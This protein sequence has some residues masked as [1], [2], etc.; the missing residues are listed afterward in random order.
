MDVA[1]YYVTARKMHLCPRCIVLFLEYDNKLDAV[2]HLLSQ[3]QIIVIEHIE[4]II[5][6]HNQTWIENDSEI[7][8][9]TS[10]CCPCCFNSLKGDDVFSDLIDSIVDKLLAIEGLATYPLFID[11]NIPYIIATISRSMMQT[12]ISSSSSTYTDRKLLLSKYEEVVRRMIV[13]KLKSKCPVYVNLVTTA[14]DSKAKIVISYHVNDQLSYLN[15][16]APD[17]YTSMNKKRKYRCNGDTFTIDFSE[18]QHF[19]VTYI[20]H[21]NNISEFN[22]AKDR[23]IAYASSPSP[24]SVNSTNSICVIGWSCVKIQ[25]C[26]I[27]LLGRYR[28]LARDVPQS[29]WSV[30]V[31]SQRKGRNS[32]D[33][34]IAH[35]VNTV[36]S[37][38]A[39]KMHAC[40][41]EDID[42]RCLG[43]GR[44][45]VLEVSDPHIQPSRDLL[46]LA[47]NLV[48]TRQGLNVCGDVELL[49]LHVTDKSSW[50]TMQAVAEEKRKAYTCIV[51]SKAVLTAKILQSIEDLTNNATTIDSDGRTCL[52]LHQKTPLRVLHRRSLLDRAKYIYNIK[53]IKLNAHYFVMSMVTSAG[54]YVKEFIHGDLNRTIPNI[55]SILQCPTDILQLDVTWLFDD[56]EGGGDRDDAMHM[57]AKKSTKCSDSNATSSSSSSRSNA[58]NEYLYMSWNELKAIKNIL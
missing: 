24:S 28:K 29:A 22:R 19:L 43:N 50:E 3:S 12:I 4:S 20:K 27:Y 54:T 7:C 39:C 38:T 11:I 17:Y 57:N 16:V 42:V 40:G 23:L 51:W 31:D 41:R 14:S 35:A 32:V 30:G 10:Y 58:V 5:S 49:M 55:A 13:A 44:P 1:Q 36:L 8:L 15:A 37:S 33:E 34:I 6:K 21:A 18:A 2:V 9:S 56:Y 46:D 48:S 47:I 52:E 53:T 26:T 45:F 25:P